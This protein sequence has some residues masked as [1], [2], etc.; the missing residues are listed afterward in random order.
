[1]NRTLEELLA[2][3]QRDLA[4]LLLLIDDGAHAH[5][6]MDELVKCCSGHVAELM[7]TLEPSET[8]TTLP[9]E[10]R[11]SLAQ[12]MR[13]QAMTTDALARQQERIAQ[14]IQQSQQLRQHLRANLPEADAGGS[15][16]IRG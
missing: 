14:E 8:T 1:M 6:R 13:L 10:T 9:E 5:Q 15:C 7:S 3:H 4:E 12:L 2:R 16:D 11:R